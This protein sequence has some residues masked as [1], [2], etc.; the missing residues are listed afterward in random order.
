MQTICGQTAGSNCLVPKLVPR[1]GCFC[2][3]TYEIDPEAAIVSVVNTP[4]IAEAC[5]SWHC[6]HPGR[7]TC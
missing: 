1:T 5:K 4:Y 6:R 7:A 2:L 3:V